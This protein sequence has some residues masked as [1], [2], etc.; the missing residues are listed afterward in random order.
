[1][2]GAFPDGT[3]RHGHCSTGPQRRAIETVV[4]WTDGDFPLADILIE[5]RDGGHRRRGEARVAGSGFWLGL[6]MAAWDGLNVAL[7]VHACGLAYSLMATGAIGFGDRTGELAAMLAAAFFLV[8]MLRGRYQIGHYLSARGQIGPAVSA[9][10][11]TLLVFVVFVFLAK[12][13]GDFSRATILLTY[14]AGLPALAASRALLARAVAA[15]SEAGHIATQRVVVVG[16]EA[17]AM[18]FLERHKPWRLGT[19]IVE[20]ALIRPAGTD[21]AG[22]RRLQADL[23]A[24]A[25]LCRHHCCDAVYIAVPWSDQDAIDACVTAFMNT[26]V[27]IHLAP[28]KVLDGFARPHIVSTGSLSTLRLTRPALTGAEIAAKRTFDLAVGCLALMLLLPLF[29]VI[30]LLIRLDS[31]GPVLF[32]QRRH[33]FNQQPFRIFK[34]RSMTTTDDGS[35]IRQATKGDTRITRIG[36]FLRRTNLDE[37]PQLLNV[38]AGQMSL[39]GPRP[40]ALAHD[41]EF[42]RKIALYARRHNVKPGITGWAQVNGLRGETDTD[43]KMAARVVCDLWYIDNWSF[44]LDLAI[45]FRTVFSAKAFRNAG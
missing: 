23:A 32:R 5:T 31:P 27:A 3:R 42:E 44:S 19:A 35:V 20:V 40:H 38:I 10:T 9:W 26:P 14:L 24:A 18:S 6:S 1:M 39:V 4:R 36:R 43:E 41:R 13:A 25:A 28:E 7:L 16:Y 15:G 37:L 17:Q 8:N 29:A 12:V 45:L 22:A 2:N 30:A 11:V 21:P 33:G 34:F